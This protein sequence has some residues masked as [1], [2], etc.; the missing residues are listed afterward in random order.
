MRKKSDKYDL[1]SEPRG[2]H[3]LTNDDYSSSPVKSREYNLLEKKNDKPRDMNREYLVSN[4]GLIYNFYQKIFC[5]I[6]RTTMILIK[7]Y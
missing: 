7:I 2:F 1:D 4:I 6:K 3:L 5:I